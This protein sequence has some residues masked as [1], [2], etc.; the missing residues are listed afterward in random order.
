MELTCTSCFRLLVKPIE[1]LVFEVNL[2]LLDHN[3]DYLVNV[4]KELSAE[5][6]SDSLTGQEELIRA[7]TGKLKAADIFKLIDQNDRRANE[8]KENNRNIV[9]M[10]SNL[11]KQFLQ[12]RPIS[13][14]KVCLNCKTKRPRYTTIN[15]AVFNT[16]KEST[17]NDSA[18]LDELLLSKITENVEDERRHVHP[19]AARRMFRSL[20]KNEKDF[21]S[22][23][24][25]FYDFDFGSLNGE[26][27]TKLDE[28][29]HLLNNVLESNDDL[30]GSKCP[31]DVFFNEYVLV[32]PTRFRPLRHMDD[33]QYESPKSTRLNSV[34]MLAN[35]LSQLYNLLVNTDNATQ[36]IS[37]DLS[38]RKKFKSDQP[39]TIK[40]DFAVRSFYKIW[41][42]LQEEVCFLFDVEMFKNNDKKSA[43]GLKQLIEKK[44][45]LFRKNVMGKRVNHAAR[46][47]ISPDPYIMVD[48]IGFPEIFAKRLSFPEP[49]ND[50]NYE[51]LKQLVENGPNVW[52][53]AISVQ[54]ENG[55]IVLLNPND[56]NQRQSVA[57]HVT[58]NAYSKSNPDMKIK[59]VNRHLRNG[60]VLL[61]NRQPTLHKPSIMAHRARV[62]PGEKTIRLHYANCKSYNADFDGDEMN[63]HFPQSFLTR[64]EGY[65]IVSV[66]Y[67]YLVPKD[68]TPLSSLI[69]DHIVAATMLSYRGEFFTK[70]DYQNLVFG[71]IS[72]TNRPIKFLRPAILKPNAL[73][74][75]KQ[76]ISTII[77]NLIPDDKCPPTLKITSKI[78]PSIL[79]S[80]KPREYT[81]GGKIKPDE[82]CESQV[83]IR[84]GELL[85]GLFDKSNLGNT[86]YGLIHTCYELYGGEIST[87][88]LT[89]FARLANNYLQFKCGFT[90]GIYDILITKPS[91]RA[92]KKLIKKSTKIGDEAVAK[93]FNVVDIN[94]KEALRNEFQDAHTSSNPVYLKML[95]SSFKS[96]NDE[97]SNGISKECLPA[98]LLKRFPYNHLQMM[99]QSG[100]KGGL[101]NAL[102]ISCLLGQIELEGKRVPLMIS[103]KT[104]PS[105]RPY[106]T[107]PKAGGF[108]TGRFLTG[109]C[110][111]E[112]FFHCMAG[113]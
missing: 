96:K 63:A 86:S 18:C 88:L 43:V 26:N 12:R 20:W 30:Y 81:A 34:I 15:A 3:L 64:A 60:D 25:F 99:I 27:N 21:L 66:N 97:T 48:E 75:G 62:L 35:Q 6:V 108:V 107:S 31:L 103:G 16:V 9:E 56:S 11:V 87:A 102:Q 41:N 53:G 36:E 52:P 23:I 65:G 80:A 85:V 57:Y 24:L 106:E 110:P 73:W 90:L 77:L 70:S 47:V 28:L 13:F 61:V 69:Q 46:S 89:A 39:R 92:R 98:G 84:S 40:R 72:F 109:I 54:Y 59:V 38:R 112:Y 78:K 17:A 76:V 19:L 95:D 45:G 101:V 1:R 104:L 33:R 91:D 8:P 100:A 14:L 4:V 37:I 10:K 83:V 42:D 113:R 68:G 7:L 49:V 29:N 111:Q 93:A 51:E 55:H 58:C 94:D 44:E 50:H 79:I 105:F 82:L 32:S 74:S 67:Q 5:L 2:K 71:A 22:K